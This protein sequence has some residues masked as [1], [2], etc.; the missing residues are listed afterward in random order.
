MQQTVNLERVDPLTDPR[1]NALIDRYTASLFHSPLWI[2]V[3]RQTYDMDVV[4]NVFFDDD[5]RALAGMHFCEISDIRG[6]RVVSLPFSDYCDPLVTSAEQWSL[7]REPLI[8]SG[9]PINMRCLRNDFPLQDSAFGQPKRARWH[10]IDLQ[11]SPEEQWSRIESSARRAIRKA[12]KTGLIVRLAE[13]EADVRSFFN[14]H[15]GIRK[16]KYRLLAQPY[17]FFQNIARI[18]SEAGQFALML[19]EVDGEAVGSVMYL[20][21]GSTL[22]YKFSA[23]SAQHLEYR[24]TDL[25]IWEGMKFASEH[26]YTFL[27]LGLSDWDQDG[28][29]RYKRKFATEEGTITFLHH[30]VERPVSRADHEVPK[31]LRLFTDLLT[32]PS[33][34]DEITER[35]GDSVYRFFV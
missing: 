35:A 20:G 24:P 23:S 33:V 25:L 10:G 16:Y 12:E 19:A 9:H 6:E 34:P 8:G 29:V 5:G 27:D 4:A 7:L 18:F 31:L 28:L 22:Y 2:N 3:L 17:R 11:V 1:W 15:L 32:E 14:L 26:G 21:W 30:A 13:S